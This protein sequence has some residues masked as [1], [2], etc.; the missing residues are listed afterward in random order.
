MSK[1]LSTIKKNF[2]HPE[3]DIICLTGG[4]CGSTTLNQ[5]FTK[6]GYK[7]IKIHN[8]TDFIKQFKYDGLIDLINRSSLNKELYLIDS[9]RTPFE[10]KMSSFF[11]NIHKNVPDYKNKSCDQL[12][13]IFNT[14]YLNRIEEYHSINPIMKEYGVEPFDTFDF[15]KRYIIKKKGNLVFIKILFSDINNWNVILSE[16]FNK[17]IVLHSINISSK[18][19]YSW[20]YNEFK[21]KYKTSNS[22]INN[23]LKNDI[24]FKIFNT[25][26]DQNIYINKFL[27]TAF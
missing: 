9:Y 16:I 27:K 23:I 13:N 5:T 3:V 19:I 15:K 14:Q 1:S 2:L 17:K 6:H 10:R 11:E 24:E 12:I 25:L 26:E 20:I 18:K 7:S 4:K 21:I 8:K 22:Y